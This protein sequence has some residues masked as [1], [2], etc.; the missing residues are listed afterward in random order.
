MVESSHD[1][2]ITI[3]H[4]FWWLVFCIRCLNHHS[5]PFLMVKSSISLMK[6]PFFMKSHDFL[7]ACHRRAHLATRLGSGPRANWTLKGTHDAMEGCA[8]SMVQT[9]VTPLKWQLW[10][11][12]FYVYFWDTPTQSGWWFWTWFF[13]PSYWECHHPNWR[14]HIFQRGRYTTNQN[15]C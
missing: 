12:S 8:S 1:G 7:A 6:S 3:Y 13:F 5:S 2:W 11:G 15:T 4:E 9:Q 10:I 14:T